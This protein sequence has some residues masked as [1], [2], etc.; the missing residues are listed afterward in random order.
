MTSPVDPAVDVS[1]IAAQSAVLAASNA[2]LTTRIDDLA[3]RL[4]SKA[5]Q[6][7]VTTT[8]KTAFWALALNIAH[9]AA[10]VIAFLFG[11]GF[12]HAQGATERLAQCTNRQFEI[13]QANTTLLRDASAKERNALRTLVDAIANPN[14]TI[15]SR[16][17]AFLTYQS[18][19]HAADVQRN[20]LRTVS[21]CS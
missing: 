20:S 12:V 6:A 10:F 17:D 14:A 7:E 8:K 19:L 5:E 9:V 4:V 16:R 18:G 21:N 11:V 2:A 1:T 3:Q 15:E 13:Q